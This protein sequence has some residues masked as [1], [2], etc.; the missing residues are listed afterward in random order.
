MGELHLFSDASETGY[1]AVANVCWQHVNGEPKTEL[2]F[3]EAR[4]AP[5]KCVSITRLELTAAVPVVRIAKQLPQCFR[6]FEDRV[7]FWTDSAI[8]IRYVNHVST[9]FGTSVSNRLTV[10]H[11]ETKVHRCR[12]VKSADNPA[13]HR[14]RGL[15]S[16]EK[17]CDWLGGPTFL[18][19]SSK[20]ESTVLAFPA[21][22]EL[23]KSKRVIMTVERDV[24]SP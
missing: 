2:L 13:D 7:T 19:A 22:V 14:S 11:E 5:L 9:R 12:Y 16:L 23:M 1:G 20:D 10:V 8:I 3:A 18:T 17:L 4:V 15:K 6:I 24:T 21:P